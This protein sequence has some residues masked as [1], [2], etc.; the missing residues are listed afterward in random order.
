[1]KR[2]GGFSTAPIVVAAGL[3]LGYQLLVR[4]VPSVWANIL[5]GGFDQAAAL[6]GGAPMVWRLAWYCHLR[7][8]NVAVGV[9][10][11]VLIALWLGHRPMTR[12]LAWLMAVATIGLDAVILILTLKG[13][14]DAVGV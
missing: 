11:L 14:M 6:P 1:M 10:V 7:F 2:R 4:L 3:I 13:G 9:G 5:P 8:L 12:P